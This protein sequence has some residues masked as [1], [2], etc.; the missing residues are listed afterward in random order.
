MTDIRE[1]VDAGVIATEAF[2]ARRGGLVGVWLDDPDRPGVSAFVN[3]GRLTRLVI[4]QAYMGMRRE[5]LEAVINAVIIN[6]HLDASPA[7]RARSA[8]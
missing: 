4:P 6:A 2:G 8:A 3:Q 7:I 1:A 5:E